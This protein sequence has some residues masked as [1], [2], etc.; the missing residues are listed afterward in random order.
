M[1]ASAS[2]AGLVAPELPGRWRDRNSP[3]ARGCRL[4]YDGAGS[5]AMA[6]KAHKTTVKAPAAK[7]LRGGAAGLGL[8][9]LAF[10]LRLLFWQ[11]TPDA[12]WPYSACYKGDAAV[13]LAYAQALTEDRP[14]ELGLPLRPPAAGYLIA[15]LWDGRD[16]GIATLRLTWCLL[17]ALTVPLIFAAV[18]RAFG[19]QTAVIAGL[20]A[21]ASTGLM[22]LSTSLNNETPYL[23]LVAATFYLWQPVRDRATAPVLV[24]W[25]IVHALA[26]L[27]RVEHAL[28]FALVTA[29]LVLAWRSRAGGAPAKSKGREGASGEGRSWKP[30]LSRLTLVASSFGL[31]LLPWHLQAW[32]RIRRFNHEPPQ[33]NAATEMALRRVEAA[34]ERIAW[35]DEARAERK[36]LPAFIRRTA[37]N[38]VAAT[39]LVRGGEGVEA[40]DFAILE[41]GLG[42]IPQPVAT[43]AFVAIYGGLN[44]YLA[45]QPRADGGFDRSPL[46]RPPPLEGGAARYPRPLIAGL[47]P[48]DLALTYPPH[49]EI[50]NHGY[51]LAGRWIEANPDEFMRLAGKKL[52]IF[53]QGAALGL[54]GYNLPLGLSGVR[55]RVDLVVPDSRG[56]EVWRLALFAIALWGLVSGLRRQPAA[57]VPWLAFLI[58]KVA[59][60]LTFFGYARQGASV[61]PVL[62]LLIA[63]AVPRAPSAT[64]GNRRRL[65]VVVA[66]ALALVAIEGGRWAS[67]PT[68]TLDGREITRGDPWPVDRHQQRRLAVVR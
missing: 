5:R 50:V 9:V 34:L 15:L 66:T 45:N 14:F 51:R 61:I 6:G 4:H 22:L 13:W 24:L 40:A 38:F 2:H 35:S 56:A 28:Y 43:H 57:L 37:G 58:S 54:G 7:R 19:S 33:L 17:G 47:P 63:L 11:A 27:T 68:L 41:Q 59:V 44:F 39:V 42:Y 55:R 10:V 21:A 20:L 18:R 64:G 31:A 48:P 29:C 49:L 65:L 8:F 36:R 52:D 67:Q 60:A 16:D 32:D 30:A 3:T 53:A 1:L 46:E 25:G 12:S 62:V 26:C 23:L